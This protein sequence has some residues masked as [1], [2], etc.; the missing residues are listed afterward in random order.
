[1]GS[2]A[3]TIFRPLRPSDRAVVQGLHGEW[4][5]VSYED[6]FYD[7]LVN[8]AGH[9]P[10]FTMAAFVVDDA[11]A[12]GFEEAV[13][14][15]KETMIGI[16]S[17]NIISDAKCD[18]KGLLSYSMWNRKLAYI[19]T[20]GVTKEYRRNGTASQLLACLRDYLEIYE[21]TCHAAYL[22]CLSTNHSALRFYKRALFTHVR[23]NIDFYFFDDCRHNADTLGPHSHL[24]PSAF[25]LPPGATLLAPAR[26]RPTCCILSRTFSPPPLGSCRA[27]LV[28]CSAVPPPAASAPLRRCSAVLERRATALDCLVDRC[29]WGCTAGQHGDGCVAR[30]G[31]ACERRPEAGPECGGEAGCDRR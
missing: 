11:K 19:L 30:A 31:R 13:D 20:L 9:E 4:F 12:E 8:S 7:K 1:M 28:D 26:L 27:L 22:H 21:R 5:P 3:T 16:I 29:C 14:S 15:R 25:R 2:S 17:A 6:G 18:E 10:Y 24:P 23:L